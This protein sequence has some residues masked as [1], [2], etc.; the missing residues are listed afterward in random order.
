MCRGRKVLGRVGHKG[1]RRHNFKKGKEKK[2]R[3]RVLVVVVVVVVIVVVVVVVIK[4][5]FTYVYARTYEFTC[6]VIFPCANRSRTVH[7]INDVD[8]PEKK[9]DLNAVKDYGRMDNDGD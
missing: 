5:S 6:S 1:H 8:R 9:N 3:E 2:G 7:F 4:C